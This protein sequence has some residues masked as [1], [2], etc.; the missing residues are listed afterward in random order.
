[1]TDP[2]KTPAASDEEGFVRVW[3]PFFEWPFDA[4]RVRNMS[5]DQNGGAQIT[6]ALNALPHLLARL[7]AER[8]AREALRRQVVELSKGDPQAAELV[9]ARIVELLDTVTPEGVYPEQVEGAVYAVCTELASLRSRLATAPQWISVKDRLPE[10]RTCVVVWIA[11][12]VK[13]YRVAIITPSGRWLLPE[14]DLESFEIVTH[15]MPLPD[16][17][18]DKP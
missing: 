17:P 12:G 16:P 14:R 2:T 18:E 13:I 7:D 10:P 3:V 5:D 9:I 11:G 4:E 1:M 8:E 6:R 15:W